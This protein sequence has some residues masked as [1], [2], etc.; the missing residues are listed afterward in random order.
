MNEAIVNSVVLE[1]AGVWRC[2]TGQHL[3]WLAI[4]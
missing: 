3:T 4:V 2:L 1:T